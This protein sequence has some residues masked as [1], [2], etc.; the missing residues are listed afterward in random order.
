MSDKNY[1]AVLS[2]SIVLEGLGI[3]KIN[4]NMKIDQLCR[5]LKSKDFPEV[6][7]RE[8]FEKI[9]DKDLELVFSEDTKEVNLIAYNM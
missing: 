7:T 9:I 6:L 3:F 1:L 8:D 4:T 5:Y 2:V